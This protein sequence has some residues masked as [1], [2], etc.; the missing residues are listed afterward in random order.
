M[1]SKTEDCTNH[2]FASVSYHII[3]GYHNTSN[4]LGIV[5]IQSQAL[6]GFNVNEC[7]LFPVDIDAY[8]A[9]GDCA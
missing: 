5:G 3:G 1:D 2:H 7:S 8:I 9:G 4:N 6:S